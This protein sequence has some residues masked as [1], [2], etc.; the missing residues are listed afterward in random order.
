MIR[1]VNEVRGMYLH[2]TV[3]PKEVTMDQKTNYFPVRHVLA[4]YAG[5]T[6]TPL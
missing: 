5:R 2:Q 6:L 3:A 4:K 1:L